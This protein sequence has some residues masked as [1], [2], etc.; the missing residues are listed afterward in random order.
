MDETTLQQAVM[1][2]KSLSDLIDPSEVVVAYDH[3]SDTVHI[4]LFGRGLPAVSLLVSEGMLIRWDRAGE[5][6]VGIQFERFLSQVAPRHPELLD[7]LDIAD[8]QGITAADIG[9]IRRTV[10][11][12]RR[13][14]ILDRLV[15]DFD[16]VTTAAD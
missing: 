14:T 6:V 7:L 3:D 11:Q 5:R 10:A 13:G 15:K 12:Q 8:L 1:Q 16:T 4:H 9:D 2:M